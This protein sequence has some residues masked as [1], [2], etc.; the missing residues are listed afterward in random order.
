MGHIV[1]TAPEFERYHLLE[2]LA[3]ELRGRGHRVTV[4]CLD[5]VDFTFWSAQGLACVRIH[6]GDPL[7][8]R[9]PL[10]ELAEDDCRRAGRP[11]TGRARDRVQRGLWRSEEHT[12]ELQS[13]R[14]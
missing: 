4:L 14:H 5:R 2:R 12:S 9:A 3:R 13:L 6:P 11:A 7:P 8:T 10:Q 1:F